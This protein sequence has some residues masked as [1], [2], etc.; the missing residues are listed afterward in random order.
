[1]KLWTL[2][3]LCTA[4][5]LILSGCATSPTPPKEIKVDTTLP[6]VELTQNG[7]I[8]DMK[9]VAFE[10]TSI[11]DPRVEGVYIYK[12]NPT[13]QESSFEEFAVIKNRFKTHYLDRDVKPGTI[14]QYKFRTFSKENYGLESRI[15]SAKT[16]PLLESVSWIHSIAG[17]P[18]SAK[19]IWRPHSSERVNS[20]AIERKTLEDEEWKKI[21]T[22]V[23]R[24]NAEYVD[25][26]LKDNFVYIYR[27]KAI[28]YD[29]IV[30]NPSH[31]VKVVTKPLPEPV[32]NIK[33]T[34]NLAKKI[35]IS[36]DASR[37]ADFELY[38][39][40]RSSSI[41]GSYELVAKLHNSNSFV[42][43]IGE[44]G[45]SYFYRV[46]VVDKDGLESEYE[47]N[48]IHGTS[49]AKPSA[50]ALVDAKYTGASI[51]LLWSKAD[52]RTKTF[53]IE[54]TQTQGWFE[55][56]SKTYEGI[57]SQSFSDKNIVPDSKYKYTIYGV[58]KDGIKSPASI[59]V[60]V[61]TP[62][63]MELKQSPRKKTVEK[64]V[65]AAPR[66]EEPQE[67]LAPMQNI[68]LS[69]I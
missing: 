57:K 22:V 51:E 41:D 10:W 62:E 5:L 9:T 6:K 69:E 16:L 42:D 7:V 55:T 60:E 63:S 19:I 67:T 64:E 48:S 24:L 43:E 33:T 35:K 53:V 46:S 58:D 20:Y 12:Q 39:V 26:G 2:S 56:T 27:L 38:H 52:P 29:G 32:D 40:Y 34:N 36:W 3:T 50:P 15:I 23:G 13:V 44:D 61:K 30:S 59:Q 31:S 45:K 8:V 65:K 21:D 1:M 28:T 68:D 54:R 4:S 49:R 11:K 14:Y 47:K 17:M 18:R 25:D 37:Q 66:S